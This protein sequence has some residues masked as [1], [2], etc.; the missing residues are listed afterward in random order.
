MALVYTRCF[1]LRNDGSGSQ[2]MVLVA[3]TNDGS[4]LQTMLLVAAVD[5][6]PSG[7]ARACLT[8]YSSSYT[9]ILGDI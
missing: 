9:S 8:V 1:C 4:G 5:L 6:A 3:A 7:A 2:T